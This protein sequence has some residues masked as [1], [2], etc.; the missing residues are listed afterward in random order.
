MFYSIIKWSGGGPGGAAPV[1]LT[2]PEVAG[3]DLFTRRTQRT[4][5]ALFP[6]DAGGHRHESNVQ[7]LRTVKPA[8][9]DTAV[10]RGFAV[11]VFFV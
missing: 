1:R 10:L 2:A 11:F 8:I 7:V 3:T 5:R 4:R 6:A 9:R